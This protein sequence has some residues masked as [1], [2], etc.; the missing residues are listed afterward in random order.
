M[1]N[2][3]TNGCTL[4]RPVECP[5][6]LFDIMRACWTLDPEKRPRFVD[7]QPKMESMRGLPHFQAS[8][9]H[10]VALLMRFLHDVQ[11]RDP[12]PSGYWNGGFDISQ[13]SESTSTRESSTTTN[14]GDSSA[15]GIHFEKSGGSEEGGQQA[16]SSFYMPRHLQRIPSAP[17][18]IP[19]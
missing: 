15:G 9:L 4:E 1:L 5:N 18:G 19:G 13:E 12:F 8:L 14:G 16:S 7:I 3:L 17:K 6:E 2:L 11:A 10:N